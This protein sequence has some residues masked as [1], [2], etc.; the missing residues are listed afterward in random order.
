MGQNMESYLIDGGSKLDGSV[1]I[2]SAKNA[3]LPIIAGCILVEDEIVIKKCPKINDVISMVKI[4]KSLGILCYFEKDSLIINAKNINK[5]SINEK[6]TK[7]L[8]S[9]IFLLGALIGRL[10]KAEVCYPGGCDIGERPIDIH[11]DSLIKLGCKVENDY[12]KIVASCDKI[13]SSKI[14][15]KYPSVGATE[16]IIL[17]SVIS[18]AKVEI[19]NPAK[20]PEIIDLCDFLNSC[21]AKINYSLRDT[22]IIEGVNKL[23]GTEYQPISDRIEAGT[24]LIASAITSGKVEVKNV[25]AKNIFPLL[26][27]LCDNACK[28]GIYND[29][30]YIK[31]AEYKKS[32]SVETL[33]YPGFPTDL[34]PQITALA[35][36]SNGIS[37]ISETVFEN[38]F[39]SVVELKKMGADI[40]LK[41]N[42]AIIKGVKKLTGTTVSAFDLR[43][44]ASLCL[45]GLCCEGQTVVQNINHIKRGYFEFDKKL[46]SLG[47]NIKIIQ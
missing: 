2:E 42:Y 9:S 8:R 37:F 7:E 28:I 32:F 11:I 45:A 35:T 3:V 4:I 27:K 19:I 34:Q 24:Y 21:G 38:R 41:D 47:A 20:E 13:K 43:G 22:I 18:D 39:T 12:C 29:I 1:E 33:P 5:F 14:M 44:G 40:Y 17:S 26:N 15:L 16:N 6:L 30:I 46:S 31:G 10:H 36:I 25:C 23:N